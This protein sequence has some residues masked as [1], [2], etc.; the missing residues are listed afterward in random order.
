MQLTFHGMTSDA[1]F[2]LLPYT[3][4]DMTDRQFSPGYRESSLC[5]EWQPVMGLASLARRREV[6]PET[7]PVTS[8]FDSAALEPLHARYLGKDPQGRVVE[9]PENIFRRVAHQILIRPVKRP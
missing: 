7:T 8:P 6:M 1:A 2:L 5:F 3:F 9:T 4:A